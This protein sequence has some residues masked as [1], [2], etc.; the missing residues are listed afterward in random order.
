[1]LHNSR[2]HHFPISFSCLLGDTSNDRS[3]NTK[4]KMR[5]TLSQSRHHRSG[6]GSNSSGGKQYFIIP[7]IFV[8][9]ASMAHV[10]SKS[11]GI[12]SK[13]A[14]KKLTSTT[15]KHEHSGAVRRIVYFQPQEV[16]RSLQGNVSVASIFRVFFFDD[17]CVNNYIISLSIVNS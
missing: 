8:L 1:M 6:C 5:S 7:I 10:K 12:T 11:V 13:R 16:E 3:N 14:N 15:F 17:S 4:D 9:L 2:P